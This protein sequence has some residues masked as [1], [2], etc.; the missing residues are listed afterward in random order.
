MPQMPG[1]HGV[2]MDGL[3]SALDH[4]DLK[5][6]NSS[7]SNSMR[8]QVC[9]GFLMGVLIFCVANL[10]A[11]SPP[12]VAI[13]AGHVFDVTTGKMLSDQVLVIDNGKIASLESA[14]SA[15]TPVDATR[16]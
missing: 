4:R 7:E 5:I 13:H 6:E 12:R 9:R 15:K 10:L 8:K 16:I 1:A 11:Q 2:W 14:T 3:C